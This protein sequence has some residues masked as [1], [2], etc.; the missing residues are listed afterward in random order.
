[1]LN[2]S[3]VVRDSLH[4]ISPREILRQAHQN[5]HA[6]GTSTVLIV[7]FCPLHPSSLA[8][9]GERVG[10]KEQRGGEQKNWC[11]RAVNLG[12]SGFRVLRHHSSRAKNLSWRVVFASKPQQH[13]FNFPY[14]LGRPSRNGGKVVGDAIE[15]AEDII[16][17]GM[18]IA[19]IVVLGSD[20]LF[21]NMFDEDVIEVVTRVVGEEVTKETAKK[22][23]EE[24]VNGVQKRKMMMT[25]IPPLQQPASYASL[26][27]SHKR[28]NLVLA[29]ANAI[30][31][32]AEHRSR[33]PPPHCSP[34]WKEA[35]DAGVVDG[36]LPKGVGGGGGGGGKIDDIT[37][38]VAIVVHDDTTGG[39]KKGVLQRESAHKERKGN[40]KHERSRL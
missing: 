6:E 27:M 15:K 25:R 24:G 4:Q 5:T 40:G 21:D 26:L 16:V 10:G 12:D 14:Q 13:A 7:Q 2:A 23:K 18:G 32:A 38:A 37:V 9:R 3:R 19:D 20:G 35:R 30:A 28:R 31:D 17:T 1:M 34:F 39:A 22:Q 8:G 29:L 33:L 36:N 11:L